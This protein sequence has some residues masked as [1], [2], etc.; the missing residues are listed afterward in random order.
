MCAGCDELNVP[1]R[2]AEKRALNELNK[3]VRFPPPK[4]EIVRTPA[5]KVGEHALECM[6]WFI[7]RKRTQSICIFVEELNFRARDDSDVFFFSFDVLTSFFVNC[8]W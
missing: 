2:R 4:K 3:K 7:S 1:V 5:D 6:Y 8:T